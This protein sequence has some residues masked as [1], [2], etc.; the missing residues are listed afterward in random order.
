[1]AEYKPDS[2]TQKV[3]DAAGASLEERFANTFDAFLFSARELGL[4]KDS[5]VET[6]FTR[7]GLGTIHDWPG[8]DS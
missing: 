1:M 2:D 3:L 4:S 7:Q 5:V 6:F 8:W